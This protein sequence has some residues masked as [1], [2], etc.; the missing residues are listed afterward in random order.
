[1]ERSCLNITDKI[2]YN[3]HV[4]FKGQMCAGTNKFM[5]ESQARNFITHILKD[6]KLNDLVISVK[7]LTPE[8]Q[9][10]ITEMVGNLTSVCTCNQLTTAGCPVHTFWQSSTGD[11][12]NF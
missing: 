4:V 9:I 10:G 5:T 1:M 6:A 11:G 7:R 12:I 3:Y 8:P 2:I